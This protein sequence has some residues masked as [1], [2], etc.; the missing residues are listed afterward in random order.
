MQ[1]SYADQTDC[2]ADRMDQRAEEAMDQYSNTILRDMH[3]AK[4]KSLREQ[5]CFA[6][7]RVEQAELELRFW[8][9][10]DITEMYE[11]QVMGG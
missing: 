11:L 5:A 4:A 8:T 6:R 2:E 9:E 7:L 3:L 10:N 1:S